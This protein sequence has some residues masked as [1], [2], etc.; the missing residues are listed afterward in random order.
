MGFGVAGIFSLLCTLFLLGLSPLA[1]KNHESRCN[2][3]KKCC[4]VTSISQ[5][6]INNARGSLIL[7]ASGRY[8]LA[9]DIVGTLI[10]AADSVSID[11]CSHTLNAGASASAIVASGHQ[12][13]EV[14]NGRIVNAIDAAILVLN[15][16]AVEIYDLTM[17]NNLLDAIRI[18]DSEALDVHDVAF[19]NNY[20]GERALN[21]DTCDS[22]V[23]KGCMASGFVSTIGAV[24]ELDTCT[25][26][27][28]QAL[29]VT[30]SS[31][32]SL[33]SVIEFT[34]GTAFISVN[35]S[36]AVDFV[37][38]NVCNNIFDNSL[39]VDD[40]V[41]HW[42]T[43]EAIAFFSSNDCTLTGCKTS[44]NQDIAGNSATPDSE[45]YQLL[46]LHCQNCTI[47][48]HQA[49]NN[50]STAPVFYFYLIAILDSS[51]VVCDSSQAN[52]N[53]ISE[54]AVIP[55]FSSIMLAIDMDAY[56]GDMPT[57]N[58]VI[59][60]CQANFNRIDN[61]PANPND[62]MFIAYR[63]GGGDTIIENCQ[64]ND[65]F[66]GS[67]SGDLLQTYCLGIVA[68]AELNNVV[69]A[70]CQANNNSGGELGIGYTIVGDNV[71]NI[72][73]QNCTGNSNSSF[74][75][76]LV[77]D[78]PDA[79][80]NN[81]EIID[82]TFAQ[83]GGGN[84][85]AG[86]TYYGPVTAAGIASFNR[87]AFGVAGM[88]NILIKG[89][90]ILDTFSTEAATGFPVGIYFTL[91]QNVVIEDT[92]VFN[93]T[94]ASSLGGYGILFDSLTDSKIIR[95]QVHTSQNSGVAIVGENE[96][97]AIIECVALDN[98]I[99]FDFSAASSVV[100]SL[101]QD[102]RAL[103]NVTSGFNYGSLP[104]TVTFIGNEAQ[105]N[106]EAADDNFAGLNSLINLQELSWT[107]GS[108]TPI[109][110]IGSGQAAL[111]ARFTNIRS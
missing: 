84:P 9:D 37:N 62:S 59:R 111:G 53:E 83:N 60:N 16:Q 64:A 73:I 98:N 91:N 72:K 52:S 43:A 49:A 27:F 61:A 3:F 22:I 81:I 39:P 56:Y 95:T 101:V 32:S 102:S 29:D 34:S 10:V 33:G 90:T 88:T 66:V 12:G 41:N 2:R 20:N 35:S 44:N 11:L 96:T 86:E 85:V 26:A 19:V 15:C 58:N 94:T 105:C 92:N 48:D 76:L 18:E 31:K 100:C 45:D 24:V 78:N 46:L 80:S 1:A 69:I 99:G 109:N 71:H 108:I 93:T 89:C 6:D 67:L 110:P 63:T 23:V 55:G 40:P 70:N 30:N 5:K 87:G 74:G 75:V 50:T 51:N 54:L 97:L 13:L 79:P 36:T 106:G 77:N 17:S 57:K 8:A 107:D 28:V 21:F 65:N 14:F 104:L 68:G 38:V 47:F 103:Y 82:C 7:K 25:N 4:K 42:R